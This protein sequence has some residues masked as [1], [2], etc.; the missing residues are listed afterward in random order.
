MAPARNARGGAKTAPG[1][2]VKSGDYRKSV[3][4]PVQKPGPRPRARAGGLSREL[5]SLN[6]WH[7][8]H[9]SESESLDEDEDEED[10]NE[11]HDQNQDRRQ[12]QQQHHNKD[13]GYGSESEQNVA[14]R[15]GQ[16]AQPDN[17]PNPEPE[18][19]HIVPGRAENTPGNPTYQYLFDN[20]EDAEIAIALNLNLDKIY[21]DREVADDTIIVSSQSDTTSS[22]SVQS[23][24]SSAID[25]VESESEADKA[26][27]AGPRC[28]L[29]ICPINGV[30]FAT[31]Q[32]E[33]CNRIYHQRCI[34]YEQCE[35]Y[36]PFHGKSVLEANW[37]E[38]CGCPDG[39]VF[40]V[41][42]GHPGVM[43]HRRDQDPGF[44]E[45]FRQGRLEEAKWEDLG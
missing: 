42:V 6:R 14:E 15:P 26:A 44:K 10:E 39:E 20:A 43:F 12:H 45:Y 2:V 19:L 27:L 29:C 16:A 31:I 37:C 25:S 41:Y 36:H 1:R 22:A 21:T 18:I 4:Q 5:A 7:Y 3:A 11:N 9:V 13:S 38:G 23:L 17:Q 24:D 40:G 8:W 32:C 28:P 34:G 33:D 30:Y 35:G